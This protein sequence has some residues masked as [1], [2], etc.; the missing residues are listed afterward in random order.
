MAP[1][2]KNHLSWTPVTGL[3][4][5]AAHEDLLGLRFFFGSGYL[6]MERPQKRYHYIS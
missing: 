5:E 2:N 4:G 3:T 6:D 1:L